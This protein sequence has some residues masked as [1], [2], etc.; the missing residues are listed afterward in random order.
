MP[1][2]SYDELK[3]TQRWVR[4]Q[5]LW[6]EVT[7]AERRIR[8]PLSE[9]MPPQKPAVTALLHLPTSMRKRIRSVKGLQIPGE[10]AFNTLKRSLSLT[11]ATETATFPGGAYV[12]DPVGLVSRLLR[13]AESKLVVVGGDTGDKITK[14]GVTYVDKSMQRFACLLVY[15]GKDDYED[16]GSLREPGLTPF[17]GESALFSSIFAVFQHFIETMSA[18]LNGD[19]PFINTL[20]GL[21]NASA[22]HPCPICRISSSNLLGT[23]GYRNAGDRHSRHLD[24]DELVSIA[25]DRI[26]P[27]PLHV[28]LGISN[29]I[30]LEAFSELFGKEEV[31]QLLPRITTIHSAGCGGVSDVFQLNGPEI[32]KWLKRKCSA[33]LCAPSASAEQR[34]THSVLSRWLEKLHDHLL[35][36]KEWEPKEIEDWRAAVTDIQ[37]NWCRETHSDA[38]PKLHML[39]HTLEF[40]ERYRFLGQASEAQI[41]SF[42]FQFKTLFHT[43]HRNMS[44]NEPERLRRCLADAAL[45][46]VQP[47]VLA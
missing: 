35:H 12:T 40:A 37:Q 5:L 42:H 45:R 28:F 33:A 31:E 25:S 18:F 39:R 21:K 10:R 2:K 1:L 26:V 19:W 9:I 32:R 36:K 29:R 41:E 38:F 30:I 24:R 46:A 47:L 23:A 15:A 16:L 27:T 4:R 8:C 6:R 43:Q 17:K 11:Q 3:P 7:R 14:L 22:L 34:A 13:Q 20:L 44:Y